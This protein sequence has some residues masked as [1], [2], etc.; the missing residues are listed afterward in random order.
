MFFIYRCRDV[1][2]T[3][4]SNYIDLNVDGGEWYNI[5][6][7]Q[8]N[9][10]IKDDKVQPAL[11][12]ITGWKPFPSVDIPQNANYGHIYH[13]LLESVV[14]IGED[15]KSEDTDLSHMTSKP[16][17]KGEQYVKSGSVTN[18]MDAVN[19]GNYYVKASVAASMKKEIAASYCNC[20]C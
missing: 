13:Y 4:K 8:I 14:L 17:T 16:L 12:P 5:K 10:E 15:G 3:G 2:K 6:D 1:V 11:A 18:I 9:K 19:K 20:W 7:E